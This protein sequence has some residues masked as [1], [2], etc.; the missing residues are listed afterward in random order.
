MPMASNQLNLCRNI[1]E[2]LELNPC[3][4]LGLVGSLIIKDE[5][6]LV[7]SVAKS[8]IMHKNKK[9]TPENHIDIV[10][11]DEHKFF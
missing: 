10:D 2:L 4:I 7:Y 9:N 5:N 6:P 3:V 1:Y 11:F 8:R